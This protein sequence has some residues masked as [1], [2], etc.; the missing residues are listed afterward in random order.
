MCD[1]EN[2]ILSKARDIQRDNPQ[3]PATLLAIYEKLRRKVM[4]QLMN[5]RSEI[6]K[7]L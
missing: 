5:H 7:N 6:W 1:F 2:A 4:T 3:N